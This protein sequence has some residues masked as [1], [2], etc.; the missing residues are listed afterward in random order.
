MALPRRRRIW[1][2]Y[3]LLVAAWLLA[4]ALGGSDTGLPYLAPALLL[5][6]PL[7]VGRYVGERR[8][9]ELARRSRP[10]PR[11]R[12]LSRRAV[13]PRGHVRVMQRGGRLVATS[14]AKR[15]PPRRPLVLTV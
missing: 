5:C 2:A 14:L 1:L 13:A 8:L 15:P 10:A 7:L 6:G 9:A 4:Q 12:P 3:L 11:R